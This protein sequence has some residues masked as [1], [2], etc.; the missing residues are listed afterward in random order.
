MLDGEKALVWHG[1]SADEILV[2]ARVSGN[3]RDKDGIGI[4]I[5]DGKAAASRA[6]P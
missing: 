2:T 3:Q 1:D 6:S 5:V 4:F